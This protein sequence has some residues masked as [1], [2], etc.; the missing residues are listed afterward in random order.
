MT[1]NELHSHFIYDFDSRSQ[2]VKPF[3][4]SLQKRS[5]DETFQFHD[6]YAISLQNDITTVVNDLQFETANNI[7]SMYSVDFDVIASS[8]EWN[9]ADS[10]NQLFASLDIYLNQDQTIILPG[11][12]LEMLNHYGQLSEKIEMI[13]NEN[14][15]KSFMSNFSE[16][17]PSHFSDWEGFYT[18]FVKFKNADIDAKA[19]HTLSIF[20]Q[21]LILPEWKAINSIDTSIFEK[22]VDLLSV[23]NQ[24]GN[25][26]RNRI[27]AINYT[28][29]FNMN[30]LFNDQEKRFL[31]ISDS[32][33]LHRLDSFVRGPTSAPG[34]NSYRNF[35][36]VRSTR[37]AAI[38]MILIKSAGS[39]RKAERL[40]FKLIH[41]ISDYRVRLYDFF[42]ENSK[43]VKP[44][45][46]ELNDSI[47]NLISIFDN[48]Q[49]QIDNKNKVEVFNKAYEESN[50]MSFF[51]NL[52]DNVDKV[53]KQGGY[54]TYLTR[55]DLP[56]ENFKLVQCQ[57]DE[58]FTY[59]NEFE[60]VDEF[61]R[62]TAYIRTYEDYSVFFTFSDAPL[63]EFY[64]TVKEIFN[65]ILNN[66]TKSKYASVD[67]FEAVRVIIGNSNL[68]YIEFDLDSFTKI[69]L[70]NLC[71]KADILP[72]DV[73]FLRFDNSIFSASM[74]EDLMAIRSKYII[75][76]EIAFFIMELVNIDY[77][78]KEI[79]K[80][81]KKYYQHANNR[82]RQIII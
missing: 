34:F 59:I 81:I 24:L 14:S 76:Q 39:P 6:Q 33:S 8:I 3:S 67:N 62:S 66:V 60:I 35:N 7:S 18:S 55:T 69:D 80:V 75:E 30:S 77:K 29:I 38:Y 70:E 43:G 26:I 79:I 78:S 50:P 64:G 51:D 56:S 36:F 46:I 23:G 19:L 42:Q 61:K 17:N 48:I 21:S 44:N 11:T 72:S 53:L 15:V 9:K 45:N 20:K 68:E 5:Q 22:C 47:I 58:R 10:T 12:L 71:Q 52:N 2:R 25:W 16:S 49:N 37:V 32:E 63:T 27:D 4:H 57:N 73:S 31:I 41:S 40:A 82:L 1:S 13:K 74:E 65:S 28:H 54:M